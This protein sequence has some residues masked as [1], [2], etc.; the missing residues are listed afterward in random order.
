MWDL[1]RFDKAFELVP[2]LN[3]Q[4]DR[5]YLKLFPIAN[6]VL[7]LEPLVEQNSGY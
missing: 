5:D 3:A 2:A 4:S 7:S 6:S 1:L